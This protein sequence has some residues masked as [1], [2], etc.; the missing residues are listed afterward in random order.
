MRGKHTP[1]NDNTR[2]DKERWRFPEPHNRKAGAEAADKAR[3]HR[4]FRRNVR[5]Q[6][7]G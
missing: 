1:S 4:K 7:N 6:L 2:V 3:K 5:R